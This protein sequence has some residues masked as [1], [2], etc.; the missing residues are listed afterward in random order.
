MKTNPDARPGRW[1]RGPLL[2]FLVC[3]LCV[4][5][6]AVN[7]PPGLFPAGARVA[8]RRDANQAE[9]EALAANA[10]AALGRMPPESRLEAIEDARLRR[11][12]QAAYR[13]VAE[14][15]ESREAGAAPALHSRFIRAYAA[16][17]AEA[18]RRGHATCALN[19]KADDEASCLKDCKRRN[20]KLCGCKLITFGC[21]VAECLF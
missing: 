13:C 5:A 4:A 1:R 15:A 6:A 12:A 11:A 21:V 18:A 16:F 3:A 9:A 7:T 19:C 8:G 14:L 20:R 2:L 10:R 17:E